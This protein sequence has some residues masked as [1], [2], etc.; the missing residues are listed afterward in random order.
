P[1]R[2]PCPCRSPEPP[3]QICA[4]SG[5]QQT[6][7]RAQE[8]CDLRVCSALGGIRT[9]NLLI[10]SW[11]ADVLRRLDGSWAML[12]VHVMSALLVPT[13]NRLRRAGTSSNTI[14]GSNVGFPR[15]FLRTERTSLRGR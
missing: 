8:P 7:R 4:K 5:T 13:A 1:V 15:P 9:P 6:S 14:V 11:L 10:R 3:F 12:T 2:R